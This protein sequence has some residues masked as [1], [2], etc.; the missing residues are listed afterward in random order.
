MTATVHA[1]P[2]DVLARMRS[3]APPLP[4]ESLLATGGEP[5]RCCLRDARVGEACLLAGFEP[6]LPS[7]PYA[8]RGAVFVHA[9]PCSGPEGGGYPSDWA[10]RPQALRAYDE[11]GWIHPATRVHDGTDAAGELA[12]VL[13]EPGVVLVHSRNVGYGCYMFAA[14]LSG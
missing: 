9:D 6:P 10:T 11:R 2:T 12:A 1:L 13:A 4:V 8:E 5:L 7:S 14:D 3:H